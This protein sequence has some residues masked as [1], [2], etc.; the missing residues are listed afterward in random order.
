MMR[1]TKLKLSVEKLGS[2]LGGG[3]GGGGVRRYQ[4]VVPFC[5]IA[6]V[7]LY[8]MVDTTVHSAY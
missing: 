8:H 7:L 1:R 5:S 4:T 3:G 2:G 6:F